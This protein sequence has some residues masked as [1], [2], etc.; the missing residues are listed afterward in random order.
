MNDPDNTATAK[1]TDKKTNKSKVFFIVKIKTLLLTDMCS[2]FS[3]FMH[4][5]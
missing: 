5:I 2:V 1:Q 4:S 3:R